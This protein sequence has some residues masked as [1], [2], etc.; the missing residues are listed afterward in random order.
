MTRVPATPSVL[1]VTLTAL[2]GC[3]R[4]AG[5]ASGAAG[6][7]TAKAAEVDSTALAAAVPVS[8]TLTGLYV[9]V[10]GGPLFTD[11]STSRAWR[12][13][14]GGVAQDLDEAYL[15]T[16]TGVGDAMR[17]TVRAHSIPRAG[18]GGEELVV[19]KVVKLSGE[20]ACPG[21][22]PDA[23][24]AGTVWRALSLEDQPVSPTL[25]AVTLRLEDEGKTLQ[26]ST[27]CRSLNGTF[28]WVGTQLTF[29]IIDAVERRCP[30]TTSTDAMALDAVMLDVLRT[31]GS[32]RIRADTLDLMGE[33]GVLARFIVAG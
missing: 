15:T 28:R 18:G 25:G 3:G 24:L 13:S 20:P 10:A 7:A 30:A 6:T 33:N 19:D 27:A 4:P 5:S 2:A 1:V 31:T 32:Y 16:R 8:G 21:Q 29:D 9:D 12:V 23:P 11:C 22:H 14:A 26:A 17:V